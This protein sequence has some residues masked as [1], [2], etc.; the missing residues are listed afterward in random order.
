MEENSKF[1][2]LMSNE[3]NFLG[4]MAQGKAELSEELKAAIKSLKE[5]DFVAAGE[6]LGEAA[7]KVQLQ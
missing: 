6:K 1:K 4:S 2:D 3:W 7:T 5:K